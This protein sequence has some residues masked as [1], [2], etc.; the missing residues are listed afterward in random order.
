MTDAACELVAAAWD[1]ALPI[2][3][4]LNACRDLACE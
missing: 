3:Y 4:W 1:P 2:R